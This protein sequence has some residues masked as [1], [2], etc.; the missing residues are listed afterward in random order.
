VLFVG[1]SGQRRPGDLDWN[2]TA[3]NIRLL[4]PSAFSTLPK[5]IIEEL[6]RRQC[7]IPQID[8]RAESHNVIKGSFTGKGQIDWAVLCSR[9][10]ESSILVFKGGS[11]EGVSQLATG[12]DKSRLQTIAEKRIGYSRMISPVNGPSIIQYYK[13]FGGPTPPP[14]DHEGIEDIFVG[15]ASVILYYN[16]EG[17]LRLTGWLGLSGTNDG[18]YDR[19]NTFSRSWWVARHTFHAIG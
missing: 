1:P 12:P 8:G 17:W 9:G 5:A 14:I 6:N 11:V 18:L 10:D 19:E 16:Q 3:N 15:K 2:K 13:A 7:M 4:P